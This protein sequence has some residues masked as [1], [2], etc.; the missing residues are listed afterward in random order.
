M[1]KIIDRDAIISSYRETG[2]IR[3]TA[4]QCNAHIDTVRR[5]LI[6]AGLY[7]NERVE[8]VAALREQGL[9]S[10]QL[11]ITH[12]ILRRLKMRLTAT[13]LIA[14]SRFTRSKVRRCIAPTARVT[15]G[16]RRQSESVYVLTVAPSLWAGHDQRG[17]LTVK[18]RQNSNMIESTSKRDRHASSAA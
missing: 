3:R 14:V 15:P 7:T 9:T 1:S 16:L 18:R 11:S 2:S 6:T 10:S 12:R 13:V 8:R 17:V 5:C 4:Q